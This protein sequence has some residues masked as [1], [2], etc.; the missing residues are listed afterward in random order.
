[1]RV[2]IAF[3]ALIFLPPPQEP[4]VGTFTFSDS[5]YV[6]INASG[7]TELVTIAGYTSQNLNGV[8]IIPQ[9][10]SETFVTI[11]TVPK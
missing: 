11:Y 6:H 4:I 3:V 10:N 8:L 7:S 1:M 5:K 2:F 9:K